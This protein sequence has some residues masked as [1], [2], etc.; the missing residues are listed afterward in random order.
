MF[1]SVPWT[2]KLRESKKDDNLANTDFMKMA[3]AKWTEMTDSEKTSF[4]ELAKADKVRQEK[5]HA[6]LDKKGY[7]ILD[8][9]SK[10]TDEKNIPAPKKKSRKVRKEK[11]EEKKEEPKRKSLKKSGK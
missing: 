1:W 9:G 7:F 8:D 2:K 6:E 3:G 5:Q 4:E 10:S 11:S